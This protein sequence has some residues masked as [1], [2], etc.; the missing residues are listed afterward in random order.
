[1]ATI[2]P[3]KTEVQQEACNER[4]KNFAA[5]QLFAS[6]QRKAASRIVALIMKL[7]KTT[8]IVDVTIR[9]NC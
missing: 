7:N 9:F 3:N 8:N 6:C 5:Q 1:M 4:V 2:P